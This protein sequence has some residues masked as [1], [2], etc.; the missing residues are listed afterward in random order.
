MARE[1]AKSFY[2]SKAWRVARGIALRRDN[3]TCQHCYGRAEE[4]HHVIE[5]TPD[6]INDPN[7][8]LNP[9]NLV[10]L[11]HDCHTRETK[12]CADIAEGFVF[13]ENG[14]VAPLPPYPV[15]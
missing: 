6:N 13:D 1:F 10:C 5:L 8:A 3:F 15:T 9:D 2:Q 11:C 14:Q 12:G 7:I 4:V